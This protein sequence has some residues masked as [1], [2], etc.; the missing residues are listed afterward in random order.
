MRLTYSIIIGNE[1]FKVGVPIGTSVMS[2]CSL[3]KNKI[4][5]NVS[6]NRRYIY[7][8]VYYDMPRNERANSRSFTPDSICRNIYYGGSVN[9][10]G[11]LKVIDIRCI[12]YSY[13]PT[14]NTNVSLDNIIIYNPITINYPYLSI[15]NPSMINIPER[16]ND[17]IKFEKMLLLYFR[18][19]KVINISEWLSLAPSIYS[20]LTLLRTSP[21]VTPYMIE[22]IYRNILYENDMLALNIFYKDHP[23]DTIRLINECNVTSLVIDFCKKED[24]SLSDITL[25]HTT[26]AYMRYMDV[27]ELAMSDINK[28]KLVKDTHSRYNIMKTLSIRI[29]DAMLVDLI[30]SDDGPVR[31]KYWKINELF[32]SGEITMEDCVSSLER[33]PHEDMWVFVKDHD[34]ADEL[35]PSRPLEF[36]TLTYNNM[37]IYHHRTFDTLSVNMLLSTI[38]DTKWSDSH[39]DSLKYLLDMNVLTVGDVCDRLI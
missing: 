5:S 16:C 35:Q 30:V 25:L 27:L 1:E 29:T 9:S 17:G 6:S 14:L 39:R 18:L 2:L 8:P 21:Y 36:P 22:C 33:Y 34:M 13:I 31:M 11:K 23:H 19:G 15:I 37:A 28:I 4:N 32:E 7:Q 10:R 12:D 20:K 24:V 26:S 38:C 3:M